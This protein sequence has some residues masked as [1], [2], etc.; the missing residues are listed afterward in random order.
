MPQLDGRVIKERAAHLRQLGDGAVRRY[1]GAQI[2]K[3]H[4]VI[5][6]TP[7][8]GRTET[9]AEVLFTTPQ[10]KGALLQVRIAGEN[11]T[12]LLAG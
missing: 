8:L 3:M 1:L 6:E 7:T 12:Q 10:P 2:G 11:G 4:H 5:V 9:F